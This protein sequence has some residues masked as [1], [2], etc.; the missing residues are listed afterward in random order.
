MIKYKKD[1]QKAFNEAKYDLALK[2]YSMALALKPNDIDLKMGAILSDFAKEDESEAIALQDFYF[3]SVLLGDD[4]ERLYQEI[5]ESIDYGDGFFT[6]LLDSIN[7]F[8]ASF[9]NGVEYNDFL[10]IAKKR[11][12]IK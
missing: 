4:K 11:G 3:S 9:E 6:S 8:T 10:A 7:D 2:F 1:A 5:I 12:D